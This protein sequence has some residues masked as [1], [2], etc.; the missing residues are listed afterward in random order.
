MIWEYFKLALTNL[1]HRRMRSYLT[2]IGIFIGIA[3][4]VAL[5]SLGQ[6]LQ[7][8]I[9]E[10][11]AKVGTDKIIITPAAGLLAP[12]AT[13]STELT[14]KDVETVQRVNGVESAAGEVLAS[15]KVEG[16]SKTI[17]TFAASIPENNFRNTFLQMATWEIDA[18]RMLEIGESG[19]VVIGADFVRRNLLNQEI[20]VG[21]TLQINGEDYRIVGILKPL[22]SPTDD[23]SVY[24]N[25]KDA[26]ELLNI[27]ERVD[28]IYVKVGSGEDPIV[29][30][31][32]IERALRRERN[33]EKGKEDFSVQTF[34]QLIDTFNIVFGIVQ[35]VV[36][37]IAGISLLVGGIGIMNTMYTA[38]LERTKEI[39]IM[40]AIGAKNSDVM[41][42][43]L[44]ESGMLG[45]VGGAIGIVIGMGLGKLVEIGATQALGTAMLRAYFPLYLIVG[46]LLFSFIVGSVSGLFPAMQAA[47]MEPV[48]ALK[49]KY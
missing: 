15:V 23:A 30:A 31:D 28:Y 16:K 8:Y 37:G 47:R 11:F 25:D 49:K 5:V 41:L 19:K 42:I 4:V 32:S 34:N 2:M 17:Y 35:A 14:E 20:T 24:L 22:G 27:P 48:E 43:F 44:I 26:R 3:A 21:K 39:G 12:G 38:V 6:G 29:V 10:E 46:T 45:T 18:G 13:L 40:K 33:V 36:L 7:Q 9:T 1:W